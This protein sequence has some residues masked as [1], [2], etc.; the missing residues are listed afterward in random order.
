MSSKISKQDVKFIK[1]LYD[2][3]ESE[4]LEEQLESFTQSEPQEDPELLVKG[5][6]KLLLSQIKAKIKAYSD[7]ISFRVSKEDW[8]NVG[9]LV[10]GNGVL[11]ALIETVIEYEKSNE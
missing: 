11:K 1:T 10:Y 6:G 8:R 3:T 2:V 4:N 9:H 7:E 5:Y